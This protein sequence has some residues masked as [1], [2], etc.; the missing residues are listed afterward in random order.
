MCL[1]QTLLFLRWRLGHMF[2]AVKIIQRSPILSLQTRSNG[3]PK[4][5]FLA[6]VWGWYFLP[7]LLTN[8]ILLISTLLFPLLEI[9][10]YLLICWPSTTPTAVP[11]TRAQSV[12][13]P[14]Q[15]RTSFVT[16]IWCTLEKSP[17]P[18][19]RAGSSSDK[20]GCS[21]GTSR[22]S[23]HPIKWPQWRNNM[24]TP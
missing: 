18:A 12:S 11:C 15:T 14:S 5:T 9:L 3:P 23:I 10:W 16:T 8:K 6:P 4:K 19:H 17:T 13:K 2:S 24:G 1:I 20:L 7:I 21:T 22:A